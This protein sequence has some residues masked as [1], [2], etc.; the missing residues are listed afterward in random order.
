MYE[1]GFFLYFDLTFFYD[2]QAKM[3]YL[4]SSLD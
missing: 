3:I 4:N 1:M 2:F